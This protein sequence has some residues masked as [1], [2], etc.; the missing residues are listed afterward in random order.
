MDI[1]PPLKPRD[2]FFGGRTEAFKLHESG[3][4]NYED[5]TSLYPWVNFTKDYPVGHPEIILHDFEDISEYFGLVQCTVLPP[6]NLRLPVLPVHSGPT[7]KLV[8]G[9]CQTCVRD[10][11]TAPCNHN[12]KERALRGTWT[13]VEIMQALRKG[14]RIL[15]VHT[16][17]NFEN[18]SSELFKAYVQVCTY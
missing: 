6:R 8:F 10:F 12:E 15:K 18:R 14:Y 3:V 16:V 13:T 7:K 4:I 1:P 9:L 17:W 5:I 2:A 11:Q